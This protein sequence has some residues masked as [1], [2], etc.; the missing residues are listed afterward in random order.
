[1]LKAHLPELSHLLA[2]KDNSL[3]AWLLWLND[4]QFQKLLRQR[5]HLAQAPCV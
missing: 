5:E 2:R 1:M 4:V 3:Q